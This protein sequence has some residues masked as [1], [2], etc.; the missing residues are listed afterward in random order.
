MQM[1]FNARAAVT[2]LDLAMR[3]LA[4]PAGVLEGEYGYFNLF[5][6][7]WD[8]SE[9]V[10][11]LGRVWQVTRLSHKPFPS[12]R[13]THGAVDGL[14]RLKR[15]HGFGASEVARVIVRVPP[16]VQRLVGR[17]AVPRPAASYARLCLPFVGATA[18]LRGGVD[19][20]DFTD[21][22]LADPAVHALAARIDVEVDPAHD[23]NAHV[24]QTVTVVLNDGRRHEI[25][26]SSVLGHPDAPLSRAQHLAKFR[27]CWRS[28][29]PQLSADRA[30]RVIQLVD[31]LETVDDV[32][33]VIELTVP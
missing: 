18:L 19:V 4:G 14:L 12:G 29:T 22:R 2:A 1:G 8:A 28:A 17:P 7:A 13:L 24:P 27:R 20:S 5:E 23:P 9:I 21:E 16:I 31:R 32:R 25:V 30:E 26:L 10:G 33:A 15:A 11:Q 3:G 6:G